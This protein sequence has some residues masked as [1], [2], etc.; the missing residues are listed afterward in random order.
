L[1]ALQAAELAEFVRALATE[2]DQVIVDTATFSRSVARLVLNADAIALVSTTHQPATSRA[3]SVIHRMR[4]TGIRAPIGL[5]VNGMT[6][7][8]DGERAFRVVADAT[9]RRFNQTVEAYGAVTADPDIARA[10]MMQRAVVDCR[11]DAPA[12]RCFEALAHRIANR[13]PSGGGGL[14]RFPQ[15]DWDTAL[16][17]SYRPMEARQCA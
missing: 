8:E 17:P 15:T 13:G 12:S 11:P 2:A 16:S 5:V 1:T 7:R 14:S 6:K 3:V 10:Q 4:T 9:R